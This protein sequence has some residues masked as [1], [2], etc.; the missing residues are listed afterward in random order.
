MRSEWFT[1]NSGTGIAEFQRIRDAAFGNDV[2][3]DGL[4]SELIEIDQDNLVAIRKVDYRARR[5]LDL[6]EARSE[7]EKKLFF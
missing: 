1:Q 7:L 3:I 2:L 6:D 5:Q 4:N